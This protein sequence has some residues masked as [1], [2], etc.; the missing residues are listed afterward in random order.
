MVEHMELLCKRYPTDH[1]TTIGQLFVDG[2]RVC[3]TLEDAVRENFVQT[4]RQYK[5]YGKTAIPA[6]R[7]K[8]TMETSGRFG[9]DTLTLNNVPGFTSVRIHSGNTAEDTEG[10]I[11]LG[12]HR[13]GDTVTMSK[14]ALAYIKSIVKPSIDEGREVWLKVETA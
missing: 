1:E 12:M 5:V 7:Y 13:E 4:I 3:F 10:C 6:G 11:I 8:I 2:E 14:A 9:P